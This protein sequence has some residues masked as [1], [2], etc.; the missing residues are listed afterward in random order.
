[1]T[2]HKKNRKAFRASR[3]SPYRLNNELS[4]FRCNCN[5][6]APLKQAIKAL[7][8]KAIATYAAAAVATAAP[9]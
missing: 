2:G 9:T 8:S 6:A 7:K 4:D 5:I 1:M 3:L